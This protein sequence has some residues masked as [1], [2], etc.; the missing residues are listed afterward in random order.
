MGVNVIGLYMLVIMHTSGNN[1][2][3]TLCN[4]IM[5]IFGS[6]IKLTRKYRNPKE[7]FTI[8]PRAMIMKLQGSLTPSKNYKIKIENKFCIDTNLEV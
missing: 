1:Y 8:S 2:V 4:T 3:P 6:M 7:L 5:A